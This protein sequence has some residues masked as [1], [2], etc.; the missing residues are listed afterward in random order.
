MPRKYHRE[1][2][3]QLKKVCGLYRE[4]NRRKYG[5]WLV[6][7][8]QAVRELLIWS[9]DSLRD[10]YASDIGLQ[11]HPDIAA[12]IE[13]IDSYL[14]LLPPALFQELFPDAQGIAAVCRAPQLTEATESG[15]SAVSSA[16]FTNARL[17][18][19]ALQADNPGN[20]GTI[21]RSAAAVGADGVLA[22]VKSADLGNPKLIRASAG[23]V[24]H[25][26][27]RAQ[28]DFSQVIAAARKA[29]M[30]IFLADGAGDT[31]LSALPT[32]VLKKPTL[33]IVGNEA[34]GFTG[35]QRQAA[36]QIISIPMWGKTESLNLAIAATLCLYASATAQHTEKFS[37]Q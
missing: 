11:K 17:L 37:E 29:N 23:S 5:Q 27:L 6:E 20:L 3:G 12:L 33:W 36:D 7:G 35:A 2:T 19:F 24:F 32:S 15:N 21:I 22:G 30:Q 34:H 14:H 9:P 28:Q 25:I 10:I 1:K 18:I 4:A 16:F 13:K 8:P 31:L 26:P